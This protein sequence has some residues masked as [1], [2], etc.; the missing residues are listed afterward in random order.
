M[1]T[2]QKKRLLVT[3]AELTERAKTLVSEHGGQV[4]VAGRLGVTQPA[5]SQTIKGAP[6][7]DA[8][9]RRILEEVGGYVVKEDVYFEIE[10]PK[11]RAARAT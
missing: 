5:I 8:L 1:A 9:R 2:N 4:A 7:M 11:K 3:R 6:G 10:E